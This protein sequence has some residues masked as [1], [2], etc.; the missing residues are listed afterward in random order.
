MLDLTTEDVYNSAR[1]YGSP[2]SFVSTHP[3]F[4]DAIESGAILY[5]L[6]VRLEGQKR[7]MHMN[8]F[9]LVVCRGLFFSQP[10]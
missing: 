3:G 6:S 7:V 1:I 5:Q 8:E 4:P 9:L 10:D 2:V